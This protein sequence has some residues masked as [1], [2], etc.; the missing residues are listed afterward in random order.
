MMRSLVTK[1]LIPLDVTRQLVM[2]F[3]Q[4]DELPDETTPTGMLL[5]RIL[6]HALRAHRMNL[7]LEGI[8]L[9]EA[10]ALVSVLHP[11]LFQ[12]EAMAGDVETSGELTT[13]ATVFDR[14][15]LPEWRKNMDMATEIDVAGVVDA[16][17][18]GLSTAG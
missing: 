6:P 15:P 18:R 14:R 10:V 1:T 17:L 16:I 2:T 7:G 4:L 12:T 3:D 13:G 11:E 9:H 5:R 8:Y